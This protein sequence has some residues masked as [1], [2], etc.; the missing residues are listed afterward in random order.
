MDKW[1]SASN[2][3]IIPRPIL[4]KVVLDCAPDKS[5]THRA[6]LFSGMA[7]GRSE[8]HNPLTGED[9]FATKKCLEAMGVNV[10]VDARHPVWSVES[11]GLQ[12]W[13][14][15]KEPLDCQNSGTTARLLTGILSSLPGMQAEL[16]GDESLSER[17]MGR[18]I[19][20]LR[21]MG[22]TIQARGD[23]TLPMTI[24]G[25]SLKGAEI[26]V[27]KA[28][29]QVKSAIML[30]MINTPG[31]TQITLP[32]GARDHT[33]HL[34]R[35]AGAKL[36]V[37]TSASDEVI[38]IAGP[39]TVPPLQARIPA[40]P[41]SAAFFAVL[42]CLQTHQQ[43]QIQMP[44]VL[45]NPTRTGFVKIL[46]RMVG[47]RIREVQQ[48]QSDYVEPIMTLVVQG[49]FGLQATDIAAEEVPSLVDEIPILAVAAAFAQGDSR[50]YGL[51][52]LRVKESD[53]LAKTAE[54]IVRMGGKAQVE[55]DDLL[56][57]GTLKVARAFQFD[58]VG[59]HRLAMAAAIAARCSDGI[60]DIAH[61]EC[62]A[63]SFPKFFDCLNSCR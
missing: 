30:A 27:D 26:L 18:V 11:P 41:S 45:S 9:C 15:P 56:I 48:E 42:G 5:L 29:A 57:K 40:D 51:S 60:C 1:P 63:V 52:E 62:V 32:K 17:P 39:V 38:Q 46:R 3:K 54:L 22:A 19:Q 44:A 31:L 59:D 35:R 23:R 61:P 36:Q 7:K 8:I 49:G 21:Q 20:P 25:Q 58:P 14:S 33:E 34:L 12:Q 16:T 37:S 2:V 55:G 4:Q 50:F 13:R 47:E 6:L 24:T 10:D 28:S 53:R 43:A